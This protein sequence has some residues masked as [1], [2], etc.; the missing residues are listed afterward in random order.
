MIGNEHKNDSD[1]SFP[2]NEYGDNYISAAIRF[3]MKVKLESYHS[4]F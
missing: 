4:Y 1:V 2:H 3:T